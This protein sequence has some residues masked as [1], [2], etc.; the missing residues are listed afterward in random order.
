[1]AVPAVSAL[2]AP[3]NPEAQGLLGPASKALPKNADVQFHAAAVF[4]RTGRLEEAGQ[5]LKAADSLDA[6]VKDR[7]GF[8]KVRRRLGRKDQSQP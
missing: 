1:M 8:Q 4:A 6:S 7:A 2:A 5:A 3:T